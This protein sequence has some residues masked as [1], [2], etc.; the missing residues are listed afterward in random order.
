MLIHGR[1]QAIDRSSS[2]KQVFKDI[3]VQ[4]YKQNPSYANG[5]ETGL[6]VKK[7]TLNVSG[8]LE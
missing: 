7:V 8:N 1:E 3:N 6:Q 5:L 2:P 4:F